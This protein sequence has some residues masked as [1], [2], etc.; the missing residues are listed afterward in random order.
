MT[1][2]QSLLDQ[3]GVQHFKASELVKGH[4][5]PS[6]L[7]RNIIPTVLIAEDIRKAWGGPVRVVSGYRPLEHNRKVGSS[8]NSQHVQFRALDLA[9]VSGDINAFFAVVESVVR[10]WRRDRP[11]GFGRYDTFIHI[12]TGRYQHNRTWDH[13]SK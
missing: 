10:Q 3:H 13:R 9:P 2:L 12:D 4:G 7:L 8:D 11:V 6:D 5:E 1:T